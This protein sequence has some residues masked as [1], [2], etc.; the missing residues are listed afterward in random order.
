MDGRLIKRLG[1]IDPPYPQ[2]WP[3]NVVFSQPPV[4]DV[5][6]ERVVS[7]PAVEVRLGVELTGL[8]QDAN[9]VTLQL[10]DDAGGAHAAT[11]SYLVGCDGA[12]S[13]VRTL[14]DMALE[15]LGFD[16]PW[17][18]VDVQVNERGAAKVPKVSIQYCEPQRPATYL[19][20]PGNHRRWEISAQP[21]EDRRALEAESEVWRL[22]SRWIT[23][24]DATLWR[25]ASYRFHALVARQWRRGRVFIAGDA[26]HQQPPFTGQGMC[27]G[28]RDVAN[29]A[30]KLHRVLTGAA[31]DALLD[32]YEV[33]RRQHVKR[34]T[35][36]IKD[37]GAVICERD[38]AAAARRDQR[39]LDEAGGEVRTVPRQQLIP[40]LEGGLRS[41]VAH[42][43][44]G[45]LFPQPRVRVGADTK[46]LDDVAGT[47]FRI[48][49]DE[50]I[51][52]VAIKRHPA[53]A[54]LDARL[55]RIGA[56]DAVQ[57]TDGVV[58]AWFQ[59]HGCAAALVRPDHYV[60]GV[61]SSAA[62]L[63]ALL[64]AAAAQ[65]AVEP[66]AAR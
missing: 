35:S 53:V 37:I 62:E 29:L 50:R 42:A 30:W 23:P 41:P 44:N 52:A 65:A 34:L 27:Q 1:S 22:L 21:G 64:D 15:D 17:L 49:M 19:I 54:R 55:V 51:D 14:Q 59:R 9:R 5:L 38:P 26:A 32:T 24:D 40:P 25:R 36:I 4:E 63:G 31:D 8:A 20:G 13:T 43:A 7:L 61:A 45:T 2:G 6:R 39:L 58:A 18:V 11:A 56:T 60:F 57:E 10:R 33:E 66:V 48:V 28:V 47:G 46:L 3:P 16:E 12:S